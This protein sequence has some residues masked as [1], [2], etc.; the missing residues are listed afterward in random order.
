MIKSKNAKKVRNQRIDSTFE[1]CEFCNCSKDNQQ[2]CNCGCNSNN[3]SNSLSANDPDV[4]S[5]NVLIFNSQKLTESLIDTNS[6][7][8]GIDSH[9]KIIIGQNSL[10][11]ASIDDINE[12]LLCELD[13]THNIAIRLDEND[14]QS[15]EII[16]QDENETNRL[17]KQLSLNNDKSIKV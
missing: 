11:I 2:C 14:N 5:N 10:D 3:N 17:T 4:D 1:N 9:N 7:E 12:E 16:R 8:K 6:L 13:K 15:F